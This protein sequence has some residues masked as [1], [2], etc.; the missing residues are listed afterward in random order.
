MRQTS[1]DFTA[2]FDVIA[3]NCKPQTFLRLAITAKDFISVASLLSNLHDESEFDKAFSRFVSL[4][5]RFYSAFQQAYDMGLLIDVDETTKSSPRELRELDK[6][7]E[8]EHHRIACIVAVC[9]LAEATACLVGIRKFPNYHFPWT[10]M[11]E[12][13]LEDPIFAALFR[14]V[15]IAKWKAI[16]GDSEKVFAALAESSGFRRIEIKLCCLG[17]IYEAGELW[18]DSLTRGL[19]RGKLE[20]CAS[21]MRRLL[22]FLTM[23]AQERWI[24]QE[25]RSIR[26]HRQQASSP[27]GNLA[28][29][30]SEGCG[31]R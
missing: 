3:D 29:R 26:I 28:V 19:E 8:N 11:F 6:A 21:R 15:D 20:E 16:K 4:M 14:D 23:P 18:A 25:L 22:N 1:A 30:P 9:R 10:Q 5:V 12:L 27:Q 13:L 24:L 7:L 2:K 17:L 31:F